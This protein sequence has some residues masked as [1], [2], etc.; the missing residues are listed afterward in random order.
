MELKVSIKDPKINEIM[1]MVNDNKDN[2]EWKMHSGKLTISPLNK[3]GNDILV[4]IMSL[5]ED[6]SLS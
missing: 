2:L 1:K 5:A 6:Y 4:K 3:A